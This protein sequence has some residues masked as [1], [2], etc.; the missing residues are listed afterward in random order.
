[1]KLADTESLP[2]A[3]RIGPADPN[4]IIDVT[5]VVRRRSKA[6]G[7]FPHIGELGKTPL[8][9][10]RH[11]TREEFAATH[12]ALADDLARIRSFATANGLRVKEESIPRRSIVLSGPVS[13]FSRAFDVELSRFEHPKGT[14]RGR[15][16]PLKIPTDLADAVEG[17]FGL[18]NRP[19]AQPHFR[20]G[21]K[22]AAGMAPGLAGQTYTPVQVAQAYDF[23]ANLNG[24]G[25]CIAILELGGGYN[26]ADF[27][28]FFGNLNIPAPQV[29]A[30]PVDGGANAPTGDPNSDDTEVA[31]DIE[32]A[33]AV[34]PG[35]SI[36]V[37]F[38]PNT[39][40]GFLDALTTAIHDST[41]KPSVV[42]ISWGGPES[43]WTEQAM[44]AFDAACQDAATLGVTVCAAAGDNGSTD[45][46][47]DNQVKGVPNGSWSGSN[48]AT[49]INASE[50]AIRSLA[51]RE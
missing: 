31:L 48:Q 28:Q 18:D 30:I 4:E 20:R 45:G 22:T 37:Y 25:Q 16:G 44:T 33:G 29:A 46:A 50:A 5:V 1:M 35:A 9:Q 32:V 26:A 15:T 34:A 21:R 39:D 51:M 19:Q 42:S 17:V 43:Q 10:R 49:T 3:R 13:T 2:G 38:A 41:N 14:Y 23:P 40:Q 6:A 8:R 36:A 47:Q 24:A 7:T 27:N 12:G 11:L